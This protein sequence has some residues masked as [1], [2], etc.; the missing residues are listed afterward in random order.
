KKTAEDRRNHRAL[1]KQRSVQAVQDQRE[2]A[3]Q[4]R[5]NDEAERVCEREGSQHIPQKKQSR[6]NAFCAHRYSQIRK[7]P[8]ETDQRRKR[9]LTKISKYSRS[10]CHSKFDYNERAIPAQCLKPLKKNAK[11]GMINIPENGVIGVSSHYT[12]NKKRL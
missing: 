2:E 3:D 11:S 5:Q 1:P 7:N 8:A 4:G 9:R 10:I 12:A 6:G